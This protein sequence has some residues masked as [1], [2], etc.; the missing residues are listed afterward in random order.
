AGGAPPARSAPGSGPVANI[1]ALRLGEL[2]LDLAPECSLFERDLQVVAK[3]R[4][5]GSPAAPAPRP[6][7]NFPEDVSENV[8]DVGGESGSE[9]FEEIARVPEAIVAS[10]LLRVGQHLVSLRRLFE[11]LL[12]FAVPGVAVRVILQRHLAVGAL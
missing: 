10:S 7:E 9:A 1:A 6:A 12:R 4:A 3:V 2:D 8:V 11:F 5:A